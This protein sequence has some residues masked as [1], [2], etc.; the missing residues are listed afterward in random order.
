MWRTRLSRFR[1]PAIIG[2]VA[3]FCTGV[4]GA[5]DA[6]KGLVVVAR[7][8]PSALLIWDAS[9]AIGDLVVARSGDDA[10]R[11][12]LEVDGIRILAAR[13]PGLRARTVALRVQYA[14]VGVE[15]V[16]YQ[17]ST[18]AN[19]TPVMLLRADRSALVAHA[20]EWIADLDAGRQPPGLSVDS[21]G[22][23]PPLP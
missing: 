20:G 10:S 5:T 8:A 21:L 13:A 15:G 11:R 23:L 22:A 16:A 2:A 4:A 14:P 3:V 9:L 17:A 12:S 18:F 19:A 7:R 6:P 1:V